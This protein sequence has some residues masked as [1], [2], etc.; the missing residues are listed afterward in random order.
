MG[1]ELSAVETSLWTYQ[2]LSKVTVPEYS[3]FFG[4]RGGSREPILKHVPSSALTRARWRSDAENMVQHEVHHDLFS[5]GHWLDVEG[6]H[7][8]MCTL[9]ATRPVCRSKVLGITSSVLQKIPTL[10]SSLQ[11][12]VAHRRSFGGAERNVASHGQGVRWCCLARENL[13]HVL[14]VLQASVCQ[15]VRT[16]KVPWCS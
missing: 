4:S 9:F 13:T 10:P 16:T 8:G 7:F 2:T 14:Q 1:H 5:S 12:A 3:Q 11:S 15:R 6:F